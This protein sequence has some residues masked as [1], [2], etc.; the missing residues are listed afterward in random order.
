MFKHKLFCSLNKKELSVVLMGIP[1]NRE[2]GTPNH[3]CSHHCK[4][5]HAENNDQLFV[6][7]SNEST[8]SLVLLNFRT[9]HPNN[10]VIITC[11][12]KNGIFVAFTLKGNKGDSL[13]KKELGLIQ[14][15]Q[16]FIAWKD[17]GGNFLFMQTLSSIDNFLFSS[18]SAKF[19]SVKNC[20]RL[21]FDPLGL[22][23]FKWQDLT[24]SLQTLQNC[25]QTKGTQL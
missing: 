15:K 11:T 2:S 18:A 22:N 10:A 14:R 24:L 5:D 19:R 8:T 20:C 16:P 13:P 9:L 4:I 12:Q 21:R 1:M 25:S 17:G 6:F 3:S 7:L 23:N